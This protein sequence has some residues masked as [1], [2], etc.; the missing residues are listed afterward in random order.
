MTLALAGFIAG[1]AAA[2]AFSRLIASFLYGVDA[3]DPAVFVAV[4]LVVIAVAL[5][6]VCLPAAH[7]SRVNVLDS[8]R[9]E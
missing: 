7:A 5:I 4:P 8:L 1:L 9:Y 3:H 2:W 6:A